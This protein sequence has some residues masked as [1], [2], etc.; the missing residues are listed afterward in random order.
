MKG[1]FAPILIK[2][3]CSVFSSY[4]SQGKQCNE[5]LFTFMNKIVSNWDFRQEGG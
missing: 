5:S 1:A 4:L 2:L 3:Q